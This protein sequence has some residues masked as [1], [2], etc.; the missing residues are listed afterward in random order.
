[1]W[2]AIKGTDAIVEV[3]ALKRR[4]KEEK[5]VKSWKSYMLR[6]NAWGEGEGGEGNWP[7][8]KKRKRKKEDRSPIP[9]VLFLRRR[10]QTRN[11]Y[12]G[13]GR[14][15]A[16][17]LGVTCSR[18][19]S[20]FFTCS[21]SSFSLLKRLAIPLLPPLLV[22]LSFLSCLLRLPPFRVSRRPKR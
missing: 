21:C 14:I 4:K 9:S 7:V 16:K 1:M 17:D 13:R 20:V 11:L 2:D 10:W 6:G 8:E 22:L 3:E 5:M 12:D 19:F 18:R 15:S